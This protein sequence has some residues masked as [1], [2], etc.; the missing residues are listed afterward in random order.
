[1]YALLLK[2]IV[3]IY[4]F[5]MCLH[6]FLNPKMVHFNLFVNQGR[7][8]RARTRRRRV[9][10]WRTT[11]APWS[12]PAARVPVSATT[13]KVSLH[14]NPSYEL[15]FFLYATKQDVEWDADANITVNC[16]DSISSMNGF[17]KVYCS[18]IS[19]HVLNKHPLYY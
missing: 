5:A 1:M 11:R 12:D 8:W 18:F 17:N 9:R 15:S 2:S 6:S 3:F 14:R 13:P 10:G 7:G 16:S 4:I 19:Q